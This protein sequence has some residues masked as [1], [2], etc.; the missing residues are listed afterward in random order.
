MKEQFINSKIIGI[1]YKNLISKLSLELNSDQKTKLTRKI[2]YVMNQIFANIDVKRVNDNNYKHILRQFINNCYQIVFSEISKENI[3]KKEKFSQ[4]TKTGRDRDLYG[5]RKNIVTDRP[6]YADDRYA[7]FNDSFKMDP[8]QQNSIGFQGRYDAI[9]N[10]N[11]GKKSDFTGTLEDRYNQLQ[12]EYKNSLQFNMKPSTPPAL[13]G[14]GGANLNRYTKENILMKQNSNRNDNRNNNRQEQVDPASF[15][16][17]SDPRGAPN[18]NNIPKDNFEFGTINDL[19]NNYDTIDGSNQ[20]YQGNMDMKQW[21]TG[22]DPS[23]FNINEST[24]LEQRLKE[25]QSE[26]NMIESNPQVDNKKQVRF[27]EERQEQQYRQP[28]QARQPQQQPQQQTRQPQQQPQQQLRQPQQVRQQQYS[29]QDD[30]DEYVEE[31]NMRQNNSR[32][33]EQRRQQVQ[34]VENNGIQNKLEEYEE[35]IGLLLDKVK[36]LQGQQ[37]RAMKNGTNES[38]D[39]I[40]LLSEKREEILG[41]VE[42]LQ[43]LTLN[44]ER[45]QQEIQ[46]KERNIRRKELDIEQKLKKFGG[47]KNVDEKQIM[48]KASSGKFT[49]SLNDVCK[50]V[51]AIQLLNYNI[52]YDDNNININNNKLY[53]SIVSDNSTN[54]NQNSDEDLLSSDE[55]NYVEEVHINSNKMQVMTI[56]V[57][58]YDIYG[59]IEM[60]NRIGNKHDLQFSLLKGKIIIKTEKNNRLKLYMDKEYQ[61]NIL[62]QLGFS[63]IIGEKYKHISDKKYN[64]KNDKLVQLYIRNISND[65]FAEFMIGSAKVHKFSKNINIDSLNK[66]DIE[67]K[68]NDKLFMPEE[69]Y[70][71]EFNILMNDTDNLIVSENNKIDETDVNTDDDLLSKVSNMMNIN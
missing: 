71:L 1:I 25:Y 49:Y 24:P 8:R 50:N 41:E 30:E 60:M 17:A 2:I 15:L 29:Q 65:P 59:L 42:R 56:P 63:R 68:L 13:K 19:E 64:I 61:N 53:F 45:Q 38:D 31:E 67:I 62:P 20:G 54:M 34:M 9:Q 43:S 44:L 21:N 6:G 4:D 26:R 35:T 51:T 55:E 58:N 46:E 28:Q 7:S 11:T 47:I 57:N 69:P 39:K 5:D 14:D 18:L 48:I 52:P 27:N 32:P 12:H 10:T 22:I 33:T 70:V 36:D 23:K 66:L 40:R 3:L 16:K 37:I